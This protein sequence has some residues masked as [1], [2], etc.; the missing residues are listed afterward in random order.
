M[1]RLGTILAVLFVTVLLLQTAAG[2]ERVSAEEAGKRLDLMF[3]HDTHS[4]INSF[5][6][7]TDGKKVTVGGFARMKTLIDRQKEK[8][9][10]TLVVDA[11]DFSMGTLVQTVFEQEAAELRMLGALGCE[12][13][14]LGNHEFDYRSAGLSDMLKNAAASGDDV[15][16]L[17]V[18]N[19]DWAAMEEA[20]LSG[21]Q[22][23]IEEGF[24]T[25]GVKDYV[26]LT[27]GDVDI[28]VLGVFGVDALACA[29]TCELL[30]RDP[31][32][33]V[34]ETVAEIRA[35]E[36]V[37]LMI[38]VSHGGTWEDESKSE[39]EKLA[40]SVPELDLIVSGH[41]HTELAEPIVHGNTSIVSAG[42]YGRR[43]GSLS[44][45]QG[46]DGRWKVTEYELLAV[47]EE[48]AADNAVQEK[49]DA[50]LD[51]VDTGYLSAFGY[52]RKQVLARNEV[53]FC[54]T[55]DLQETHTEQNLGDLISDAYVYAVTQS[56]DFD[57]VAVDLAVIPSGTV[58]DTYAKGEITVENVYDSFSLG[59]GPDG[60]PGYPLISVWLT[61]KELKTAAEIDASITDFMKTARLYISGLHFNYNPNRLILNKVTDVYLVGPDGGRVEVEDQKLYR[62]VADLYT[63]QMLGAVTDMSYG[64]LSI[65]PKDA[66]GTPIEDFEDAIL[67]EGGRELKAW[68]AIARYMASF[69]DTDADGVPDVPEYYSSWHDR[70]VVEEGR[71]PGDLLRNPSRYAVLLVGAVLLVILV[72]VLLAVLVIKW[73]KG[74]KKKK[75]NR[76]GIR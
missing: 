42:E 12:V 9:P 68:D 70:K 37:D 6:T 63:G 67:M 22:A 57:G 16:E 21:G 26:V 48:I 62:V 54:T 4:H 10:D 18:C 72:V 20:G 55:D 8:N 5:S 41:T 7:V 66:D 13:T 59:V 24:D 69:P 29:P 40:K 51:A 46:E 17:V 73:I 64:L 30:F 53:A 11:G 34:K 52:T 71:S 19:V 25:Y 43:L 75:A 33:A 31:V 60:V 35:D 44:M 45:E 49:A 15:P 56:P 28:A 1:K 58:R 76:I 65:V 38:C 27:K 39:D 47:T 61:G 23:L 14:T 36:D 50:F 2:A 32:E 3:T 74:M